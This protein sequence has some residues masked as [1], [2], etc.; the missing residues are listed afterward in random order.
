MQ[1]SYNSDLLSSSLNAQE[2]SYPADSADNGGVLA[3]LLVECERGGEGAMVGR[4]RNGSIFDCIER[5]LGLWCKKLIC[6]Y[7]VDPQGT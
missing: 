2:R 6:N 5:L 1:S 4:Y 7:F 3:D